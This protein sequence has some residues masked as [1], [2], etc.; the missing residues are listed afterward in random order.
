MINL[1]PAFPKLTWSN[2]NTFHFNSG[3]LELL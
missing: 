2:P 1:A 3:T